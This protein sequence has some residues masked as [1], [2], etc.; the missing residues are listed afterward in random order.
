M[1]K[2]IYSFW[3]SSAG[4][5][6]NHHQKNSPWKRAKHCTRFIWKMHAKGSYCKWIYELLTLA[7][8][9]TLS[10]ILGSIYNIL[11]HIVTR[12]PSKLKLYIRCI[13]GI[14]S[15][16]TQDISSNVEHSSMVCYGSWRFQNQGVL[17][18]YHLTLRSEVL[19]ALC[20]N[21]HF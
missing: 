3:R 8:I 17:L 4:R 19:F 18:S 12:Q 5:I 10:C 7:R 6:N 11:P 20:E 9:S 2:D 1:S 16:G 14:D 21:F 15:A 13:Q